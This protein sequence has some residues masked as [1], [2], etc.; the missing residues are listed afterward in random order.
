MQAEFSSIKELR[1]RRALNP[2]RISKSTDSATRGLRQDLSAT[3]I[4]FRLAS[5]SLTTAYVEVAGGRSIM[6]S[7]GF[8]GADV[9]RNFLVD[10][11]MPTNKLKLSELPPYPDE[12][13]TEVSLDSHE[14][15]QPH[16]HD[17]YLPPGMQDF[18]PIFEFGHDL[19][20]QTSVNSFPQR[21]FLIDTGAFD[22]ELSLA[23]AKEV[24]KVASEYDAEVKGLSGKVEEDLQRTKRY[25]SIRKYQAATR[26]SGHDR[27]DPH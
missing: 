25:N 19:L 16:R 2:S 14:S 20:I 26:R 3:P 17:R 10:I 8:I 27:H 22:N 11:Y 7:D 13:P 18:T 4:K 5:L 12:P 21:L 1:T 24:T 6:G 23:Y 9:F 15:Q